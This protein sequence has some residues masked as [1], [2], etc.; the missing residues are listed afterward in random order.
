MLV[1]KIQVKEI[2]YAKNCRL[3][4]DLLG[5]AFLIL[6]V[7]AWLG[8]ITP[9][10]GLLLVQANAWDVLLALVNKLPWL[11]LVGLLLV[12]AG[13]KMVGIKLPF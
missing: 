5:I 1:I 10:S 4:T 13:M 8:L 7:L 6:N 12:Y 3:Y 11:S 9:V 2:Q